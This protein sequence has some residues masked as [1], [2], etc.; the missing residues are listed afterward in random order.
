MRRRCAESMIRLLLIQK[1]S[2]HDWLAG[3]VLLVVVIIIGSLA[4]RL[5]QHSGIPL[6]WDFFRNPAGFGLSET[7]IPYDL[8][9][10]VTRA[11]VAG[12]LNTLKVSMLAIVGAVLLGT[13]VALCRLSL[14]PVLRVLGTGYVELLRNLPLLLL[15]LAWYFSM[16]QGLPD[17]LQPWMLGNVVLDKGGLH[18]PA[19]Y[20]AGPPLSWAVD[21][22]KTTRFGHAG[23]WVLS[24]EFLAL[25]LALTTYTAAYIAEIIRGGLLSV[26]SGQVHAAQGLGLTPRQ[27]RRFVVFPQAMKMI[28]PS[29]SNQLL[30]LTKNSSLAVAIGYPE[31]MAVSNTVI[32]QTGRALEC[33]LTTMAVYLLLSIVTSG[34]LNFYNRRVALRGLEDVR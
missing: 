17:N 18:V 33:V 8:Q 31:L 5:F 20:I 12:L 23:G 4:I 25:W 16:A 32:N 26:R 22:P 2:W 30:N 7:L 3:T 13:V 1:S 21:S 11:F 27:V 6:G 19:V 34:I 15:V 10:S 14:S 9:M 24:P 29:L 28:V